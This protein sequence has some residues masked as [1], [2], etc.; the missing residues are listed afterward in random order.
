MHM[1]GRR[2]WVE[3]VR[4]GRALPELARQ[5]WYHFD[6]QSLSALPQPVRVMPGDRLVA[7]CEWDTS[8]RAILTRGA[9]SPLHVCLFLLTAVLP[10]GERT[11]NEMCNAWLITYPQLP[12]TLCLMRST[13]AICGNAEEVTLLV[14]SLDLT[15]LQERTYLNAPSTHNP[16]RDDSCP[17]TAR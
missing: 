1:T 12:F 7:H 6:Y 8:D 17:T 14:K 2:I 3:H 9:F 11:F 4:A 15:K 13:S 16:F 10:G 5:D